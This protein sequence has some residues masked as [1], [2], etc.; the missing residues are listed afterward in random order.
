MG[1]LGKRIAPFDRLRVRLKPGILAQIQSFNG[2]V[3]TH[4]SANLPD[5]HGLP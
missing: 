1:W 4:T 2:K 3:F 5:W